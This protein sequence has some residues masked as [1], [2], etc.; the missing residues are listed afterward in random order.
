MKSFLVVFTMTDGT[1]S[2]LVNA[3]TPILAIRIAH[4]R[5][6]NAGVTLAKCEAINCG[7]DEVNDKYKE[8]ILSRQD[9]TM[10]QN[11][12]IVECLGRGI[13]M[14]KSC[15]PNTPESIDI[16]EADRKSVV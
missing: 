1:I 10:F 11:G 8:R 16:H 3:I 4:D 6:V 12:D 14:I 2:E 13:R 5:C 15:V 9:S 7:I